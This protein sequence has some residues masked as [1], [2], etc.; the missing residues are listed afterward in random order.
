MLYPTEL[1]ARRTCCVILPEPLRWVK[2]APRVPRDGTLPDSQPAVG[3]EC[4]TV[5][6]SPA[7]LC[8][9]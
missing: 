7:G 8:R 1:R 2:N 3:D 9:P 5:T 6:F 4:H